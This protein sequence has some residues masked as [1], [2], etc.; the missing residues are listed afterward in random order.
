MST[1]GLGRCGDYGKEKK[2]EKDRHVFDLLLP[3]P[4]PTCQKKDK[5]ASVSCRVVTIH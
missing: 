4:S 2:K 1:V 3:L 5:L